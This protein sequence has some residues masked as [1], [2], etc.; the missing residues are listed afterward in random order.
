MK[1]ALFVF[2]VSVA[3]TAIPSVLRA[4]DVVVNPTLPDGKPMFVPMFGEPEKDCPPSYAGSMTSAISSS[5]GAIALELRKLPNG[6]CQW[7]MNREETQRVQGEEQHRKDLYWALR[8]RVLTDAE[9]AEV[10]Q[11]G[12][13]LNINDGET[14]NADEKAREL[15]DALLQQYRLRLSAQKH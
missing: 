5:S 4:D 9:M 8:S 14:Y 1:Y 11:Y 12:A 3:L 7:Q 15:N 2:L 10:A 6:K 13:D